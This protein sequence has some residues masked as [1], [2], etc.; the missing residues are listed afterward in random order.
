[1]TKRSFEADE[2]AAEAEIAAAIAAAAAA[3]ADEEISGLG[4]GSAMVHFEVPGA[5]APQYAKLGAGRKAGEKKLVFMYLCIR[6]LGETP[7][8]MLA[9]DRRVRCKIR[10]RDH[11]RGPSAALAACRLAAVES[12][13]K[14]RIDGSPVPNCAP[15]APP[16]LLRMW[17]TFRLRRRRPYACRLRAVH[18]VAI[19]D[20]EKGAHVHIQDAEKARHVGLACADSIGNRHD[21]RVDCL[22]APRRADPRG[23]RLQAEG[24]REEGSLLEVHPSHFRA[25]VLRTCRKNR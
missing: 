17:A 11:A 15:G 12:R 21:V 1:M 6:G 14:C 4:S 13:H 9:E 18:I 16:V 22:N 19:A 10:V 2:D 25:V 24:Q 3:D 8:L 20:R 23:Q 5:A 7:R